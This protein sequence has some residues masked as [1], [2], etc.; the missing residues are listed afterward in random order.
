MFIF[1]L[2]HP[3]FYY[4][5]SRYPVNVDE[6]VDDYEYYTGEDLKWDTPNGVSFQIV[7]DTAPSE[8]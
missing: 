5:L 2:F 1:L 3:Q 8:N 6:E 4:T 7:T